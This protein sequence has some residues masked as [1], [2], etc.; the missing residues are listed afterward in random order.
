MI[1]SLLFSFIV[2]LDWYI[3]VCIGIPRDG[4]LEPGEDKGE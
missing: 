2:H 4:P 1:L 3:D